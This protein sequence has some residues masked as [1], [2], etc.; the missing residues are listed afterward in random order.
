MSVVC[1]T[2]VLM[3]TT[4]KPAATLWAFIALSVTWGSSFLFIK[5]GLDGLTPHQV[6]LARIV[7]GGL[8]LAAIMAVTKRR[9]PRDL[10]LWGH[11]TVVGIL[12]CVVPFTL[13]AWAEQFIPSGLASIYNATTP[14]MTLLLTPLVLSSQR[15][16][17][18]QVVGLLIGIAG[19]TVLVAPWQ[20]IGNPQ[21]SFAAN[22]ACLAAPVCYGFA[23]L[24]TRRFVTGLPY[25][26]VTLAAVQLAT[27]ST[28]VLV[29]APFTSRAPVTLTPTIVGSM[30]ALGA[31]G[32][33][34][35]Y[36]W[37]THIIR[38]WGPARASTVTY[39]TPVIG[40]LLGVIL[41]GETLHWYEPVGG[42]IVVLGILASQRTPQAGQRATPTSKHVQSSQHAQVSRHAQ[43]SQHTQSSRHAQSS[44]HTPVTN[45]AAPAPTPPAPALTPPTPPPTTAHPEQDS[46]PRRA[47]RHSRPRDE[48]AQGS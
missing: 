27:A 1:D 10:R 17:R 9:W 28:I 46:S 22:L 32:T 39:L 40:V 38:E 13:F 12:Y 2:L 15:L 20:F 47:R 45:E 11:L 42:V 33:G 3:T 18:F 26:A 36:A 41:L 23:G 25:D 44:Q 30:L 31:L 14:I 6:V 24:Y 8:T 43:S 34:F 19:V 5:V 37:N 7:L 35:A 16:G 29:L 4:H 21:G 48:P